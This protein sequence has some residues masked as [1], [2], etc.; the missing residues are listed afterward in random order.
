M[1]TG[2]LNAASTIPGWIGAAVGIATVAALILGG[3]VGSAVGY[4]GV[5]ADVAQLKAST[6]RIESKV[7]L[8][9]IQR[10]QK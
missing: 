3:I 7:D 9:L 10:G 6:V 4:G 1:D 2:P 5:Q 8:I